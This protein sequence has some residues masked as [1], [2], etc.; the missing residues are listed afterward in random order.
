[1][2]GSAPY[3]Y[4]GTAK[5]SGGDFSRIGSLSMIKSSVRLATTTALPS[6][7]YNT[8]VITATSNGALT[9]DS[10]L[11][12]VG[13]RILIK[14]EG[15]FPSHNGVYSVTA[16]GDAS[17]PFIL[18]RA[19]DF[20]SASNVVEGC[21]V[22]VVYGSVNANT[23]WEMNAN[24]SSGASP[25][26]LD[27]SQI[28]FTSI[29]AATAS[30]S[31][32]QQITSIGTL[33]QPVWLCTGGSALPAYTYNAVTQ[34]ITAN[35]NGALTLDAV[36]VV[37]GNRVLVKDEFNGNPASPVNG[38]Y[39]VTQPGDAGTPY[40]LTRASD[41]NSQNNIFEGCM[42]PVLFGNTYQSTIYAMA[43]A[44]TQPGFSDPFVFETS[45][46]AFLAQFAPTTAN[47]I[48]TGNTSFTGNFTAVNGTATL[49]GLLVYPLQN[50]T[51][52][53][54]QVSDTDLNAVENRA[55]ALGATINLSNGAA[56]YTVTFPTT[57]VTGTWIR[58]LVIS[59]LTNAITVQCG[60]TRLL[61]HVLSSDGTSVT[62]FNPI[63]SASTSFN[64]TTTAGIGDFFEFFWTGTNFVMSARVGVHTA[65]GSLA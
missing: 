54:I 53:F 40:I 36:A 7:T 38:I 33:K 35:A 9:L 41:F 60:S 42:V 48:F 28:L 16:S 26:T 56:P 64:I 12:A 55:G 43:A 1:M 32:L 20:N 15:G 11:V 8:S 24:N 47:S 37:T 49:N 25:F 30:P 52:G 2:S 4:T 13:D 17:H 51:N 59:T 27:T 58:L 21:L 62:N 65:V 45:P 23:L 18:T 46:I 5:F 6:Y 34:K 22:P 10:I 19:T 14:D 31:Q 63:A 50:N 44:S 39:V 57:P 61:G 3:T 29:A